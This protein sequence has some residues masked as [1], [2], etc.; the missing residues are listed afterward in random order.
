[1]IEI[2]NS[3]SYI[4]L[5]CEYAEQNNCSLVHFTNKII[6][7]TNDQELKNKVFSFYEEFLPEDLLLILK[8]GRD[9]CIQFENT[10]TAIINATS[11]FPN[12]SLL[13]SDEY[14]WY[15]HV[16]D[17]YGDMVFENLPPRPEEP[18]EGG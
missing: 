10:D 9:N 1:M 13:E 16:V 12:R 18:A 17:N 6:E 11:W 3:K 5:M 14:Y 8:N 4:D 7:N 15:C 2:F